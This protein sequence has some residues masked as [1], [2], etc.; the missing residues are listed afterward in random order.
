MFTTDRL[1]KEL[2]DK[3]NVISVLL[4]WQV[5]I[6]LFAYSEQSWC[7]MSDK[8]NLCKNPSVQTIIRHNEFYKNLNQVP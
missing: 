7:K 8:V 3:T 5:M 4:Y 1:L 6:N 2:L